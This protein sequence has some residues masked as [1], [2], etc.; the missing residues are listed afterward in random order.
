MFN[1]WVSIAFLVLL[2]VPIGWFLIILVSLT[3]NDLS[4]NK[5]IPLHKRSKNRNKETA[6]KGLKVVK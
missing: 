4:K 1:Y 3:A 6:S 2:L 5:R